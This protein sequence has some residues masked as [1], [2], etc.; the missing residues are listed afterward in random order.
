MKWSNRTIDSKL[1]LKAADNIILRSKDKEENVVK[2]SPRECA[3][4]QRFAEA[5]SWS[6]QQPM[7]M[8]ME[9]ASSQKEFATA[10]H[11]DEVEQCNDDNP[12]VRLSS[13]PQM[14]QIR[15]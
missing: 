11:K 5:L 6:L 3:V 15:I 8:L 1:A 10:L 14:L 7:L 12:T 4:K 2:S 13:L 9:C